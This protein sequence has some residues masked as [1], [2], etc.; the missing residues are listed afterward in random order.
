MRSRSYVVNER[1]LTT[2]TASQ[3]GYFTS[4]QAAATEYTAPKRNYHTSLTAISRTS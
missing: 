1:A 3:G 4:K 2:L